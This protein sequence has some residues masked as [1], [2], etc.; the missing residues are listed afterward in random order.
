MILLTRKNTVMLPGAD[1]LRFVSQD[2][3]VFILQ[4]NVRLRK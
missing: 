3:G 4:A 2:P 1:I